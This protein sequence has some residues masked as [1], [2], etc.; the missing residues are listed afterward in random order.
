MILKSSMLKYTF[1]IGLG[2]LSLNAFAQVDTT[3][4]PAS[5]TQQSTTIEEVEVI[6]DYRPLLA[7]S[8][9]IRRRPN[10]SDTRTCQ[11]SVNYNIIDKRLNLP[12][13]MGQLN[14]QELQSTRA[15]M[16]TITYAK[17]GIGIF[18]TILGEVYVN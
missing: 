6:R 7:D 13:G 12:S 9:K 14:I 8:A 3:K 18:N 15:N 1:I 5:N 17:L 11:P 16:M 4:T 2:V 10:L